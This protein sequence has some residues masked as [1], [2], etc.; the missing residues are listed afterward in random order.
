MAVVAKNLAIAPNLPGI[1]GQIVN[2][3]LKINRVSGARN[4]VNLT[5]A[6]ALNWATEAGLP[7]TI[8]LNEADDWTTPTALV[9]PGAALPT[10]TFLPVTLQHLRLRH[11]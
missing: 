3:S 11:R 5:D 8:D 7:L 2:G 6:D 1:G 9:D 4:N 10:P